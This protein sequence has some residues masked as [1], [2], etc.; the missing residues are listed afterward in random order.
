VSS[1]FSLAATGLFSLA[2]FFSETLLRPQGGYWVRYRVTS[3][4]IQ[5]IKIWHGRENQK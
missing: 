4:E 2:T 3:D 5:I 1:P